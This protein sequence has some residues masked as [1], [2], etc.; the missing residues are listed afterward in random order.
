MVLSV[1]DGT[2][3][4]SAYAIGLL[5]GLVSVVA[6]FFGMRQSSGGTNGGNIREAVRSLLGYGLPRVPGEFALS[7]IF[8]LPVIVT[9]QRG[10]VEPAGQLGFG[11]TLVSLA[12]SG[13]APIGMFVLPQV[14]SRLARGEV[15]GVRG[16]VAKLLGICIGIAISG[17][18][19]LWLLAPAIVTLG[20][21]KDFAEAVPVVRLALFAVVPY[22]VYV[23]LRSVLDAASPWPHNARNLVLS[24]GCFVGLIAVVPG[25][26]AV[27]VAMNISVLILAALS[28]VDV[29][30]VL[31][32]SGAEPVA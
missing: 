26:H 8:A 10:G 4:Q 3:V 25:T 28:L 18:L 16:D 13:F 22:V 23:V 19:A 32:G 20:L 21:G 12:S 31:P 29:W 1:G 6:I 9:A 15:A 27:T 24:V 7:A 17:T 2:V 5:W 14:A 11:I 30:R